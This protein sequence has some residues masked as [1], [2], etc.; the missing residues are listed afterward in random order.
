MVSDEK[1]GDAVVTLRTHTNDGDLGKSA[2]EFRA[3]A[4]EL[5]YTLL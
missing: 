1:E 5:G 4:Q 2:A 3:E